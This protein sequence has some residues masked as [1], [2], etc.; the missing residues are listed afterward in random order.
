MAARIHVKRHSIGDREPRKEKL[1]QV[2]MTDE[3]L[4]IELA[5]GSVN[6]NPNQG[7]LAS[8]SAPSKVPKIPNWAAAPTPPRERPWPGRSSNTSTSGERA[9]R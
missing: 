6:D 1:M 2:K 8:A 9:P 4:A 7:I 3:A 5:S